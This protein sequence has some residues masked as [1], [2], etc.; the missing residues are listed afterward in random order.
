MAHLVVVVLDDTIKADAASTMKR[1]GNRRDELIFMAIRS[2]TTVPTTEAST[3]CLEMLRRLVYEL[4]LGR[5][6]ISHVS[7]LRHEVC[8]VTLY[9]LGSTKCKFRSYMDYAVYILVTP[10]RNE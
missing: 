3:G 2:G 5:L 1:V 7:R 8:E 6:R 10:Q 9:S 4:N